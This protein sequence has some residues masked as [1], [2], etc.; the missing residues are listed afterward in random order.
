MI[1][2]SVFKSN[3]LGKDGFVWWIGRVADPSVW[4]DQVKKFKDFD[5]DFAKEQWNYRCKVRIVG[6]HTFNQNILKDDDLPWAHILTSASDGAPAMGGFGKMPMLYGGES[7]LGFFLDGEEAQ[8]PVIV[9]TF[10]KTPNVDQVN[11]PSGYE[12]FSGPRTDPS[13]SVSGNPGGTP[14]YTRIPAEKDGT[15]GAVDKALGKGPAFEVKNNTSLVETA[16]ASEQLAG[17]GVSFGSETTFSDTDKINQTKNN[18]GAQYGQPS[19]ILDEIFSNDASNAGFLAKFDVLEPVTSENGCGDNILAKIK[20]ILTSF[21]NF[22]NRL[23]STIYGFIDPVL[24]LFY[25]FQEVDNFACTIARLVA[26][27]LKFVLNGTRDGIMVTIGNLFTIFGITLPQPQQPI[28]EEAGKNVQNI[29]FCIFEKLIDLLI[30]FLCNSLKQLAGKSNNIPKCAVDEIAAAAIGKMSEEAEK[31]LNPIIS[32]IEWLADG[33]GSIADA[34]GKALSIINQ[35]LSFL[36]CDSLKCANT[37]EWDPFGDIEFPSP[38]AW[39]DVL[40][41][42]GALGSFGSIDKGVGYLSVFG[43]SDTPFRKCREKIVNPTSQDPG[44]VGGRLPLGVRGPSCIPPE[45]RVTGDGFGAKVVPIV[46]NKDGSILTFYVSDV[47]KGYTRGPKITIVDKTNYGKGA[48]ASSTVNPDGTIGRVY[49]IDE[50]VKY[51]P[52]SIQ[53]ELVAGGLIPGFGVGSEADFGGTGGFGGGSSGGDGGLGIT[54]VGIVTDI[55][56]GGPGIGYTSGDTVN[57]GDC[58]YI[59]ILTP[60]GSIIGFQSIFGCEQKFETSPVAIINTTTGRGASLFPVLQYTPQ[61]NTSTGPVG[62]PT[63]EVINVIQCI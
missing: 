10:Y 14:P 39:A 20:A 42:L 35:I 61:F 59:P 43:S 17:Q 33:F 19:P 25:S 46:S 12:G 40:G 18:A 57:I 47:G 50:G 31:A 52:P 51:C 1:D 23:E 16:F 34:I 41:N 13:L 9:S 55:V 60:R 54:N 5:G 2:E 62:I 22:L 53:Q 8:Q 26:S 56:V 63:S 4:R 3:F 7:V 48:T 24:N 28:A 6:Y 49:V 11:N 15:L 21:T 58:V 29:I 45:V 44:D 37:Y 30:D 38:D 27:I 36:T 32:G